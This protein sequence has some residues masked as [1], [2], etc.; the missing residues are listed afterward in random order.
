[1][2]KLLSLEEIAEAIP[3]GSTVAIGGSSLSRKP[4]ALVRALV[5]AGV[6]DLSLVVDVG[7]PEVDL[8]IAA[9]AVRELR[10]AFVG[11]E[12]LGLAPHFRKARQSGTVK[13]QEWT[14]Y[15]VMAG[16]DATVKRIPFLPTHAGLA[17]DVL[18]V[19][20]AFKR[21]DDPF[22]GGPLIAV[23]AIAPDFALI[24]VNY[25]DRAGNGVILGDTHVDALCAKAART[26]FMS[27]E[28]IVTTETLKGLG[29]GVQ[30]LR[31]YTQGVAEIPWGAHPTE[32]SPHYRADLDALGAYL[33]AS[34]SPEAW[35]DYHQRLISVDH[36]SYIDR[37]GGAQA[38]QELLSV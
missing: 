9:G 5:R 17:T 31:I 30:I 1:M 26:T 6:R 36:A 27:C 38:L 23:P 32:A 13:F 37:H 28:Q 2:D 11:F 7:G 34:A 25:A 4:M 15:T 20:P 14:E 29:Q 18:S 19:N 24:H 10:Y 3:S 33:A 35:S 8:L 21:I 16:L 12:F 22:G